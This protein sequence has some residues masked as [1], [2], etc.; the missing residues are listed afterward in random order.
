MAPF[1][2]PHMCISPLL[3]SKWDSVFPLDRQSVCRLFLCMV[4]LYLCG[5]H[6]RN[7][8]YIVFHFIE[9]IGCISTLPLLR[10]VC[11]L[12]N[13]LFR[14]GKLMIIYI[15]PKHYNQNFPT[16]IYSCFSQ[17]EKRLQLEVTSALYGGLEIEVISLAYWKV[18]G[19]WGAFGHGTKVFFS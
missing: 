18:K 16:S 1:G 19:W 2:Q 17:N 5:G 4:V 8:P 14:L 6:L 9:S 13:V 10:V 11:G 12:C 7:L 15:I 3:C